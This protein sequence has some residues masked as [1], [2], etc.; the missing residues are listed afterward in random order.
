MCTCVLVYL[1]LT[2]R[3]IMTLWSGRFAGT[4][5]P[6]AW[7][8]NTSLP[9]DRRLALQDVRGSVAWAEALH[10]AKVLTHEECAQIV[11][12][13]HA[14][15]KEFTEEKFAFEESDEDIHTAVERRL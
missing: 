14:I 12:G 2:R 7:A 5:D 6:S 11:G 10:E 13:L 8:L 9:F 15:D 1:L 3:R 4:L